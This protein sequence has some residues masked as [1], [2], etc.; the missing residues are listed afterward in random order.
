MSFITQLT[1]IACRR[2][3]EPSRVLYTCPEC[4]GAKGILDVGYDMD[5]VRRSMT[6]EA[7][8]KR[9]LNHWRYRELLPLD[10]LPN[11]P[12]G[13]TPIV[14]SPRLAKELDVARVR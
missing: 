13:W 12:V 8:S 11:W 6:W 1:C 9:P 10:E 2:L 3:Y 14:E 7:L 5:A 4:G